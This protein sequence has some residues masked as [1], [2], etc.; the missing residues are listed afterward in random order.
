MFVRP[1][2]ISD[3]ALVKDFF[4]D[5]S[6]NSLYRRFISVRK[7]MPHER[8]QEFVVIDYTKELVILALDPHQEYDLV[9]GIGQYCIDANSH[10]AEVSFVVRDTYQNKRHRHRHALLPD[11]ASQEHGLLGFTAEVLVENKPMLRVFEK[12]GFDMTKH[13]SEVSTNCE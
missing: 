8:L 9:I 4:Y 12:A 13:L 10:T 6:D 5:L 1:V 2:K 7:D 3:E 11:L